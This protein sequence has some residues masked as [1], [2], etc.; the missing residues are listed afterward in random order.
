[1][2]RRDGAIDASRRAG[3][4][5][6]LRE[7]LA[8]FGLTPALFRQAL[9]HRSYCAEAPSQ[10]S[11]ERLEL[12][13]DAVLG[14]V[15]T[16]HLYHSFPDLPEGDLVRVRA[17]VVSMPGLA[18][19]AAELGLG[20]AILL[21]KGEESS[22][23]RQKSSILADCLEAVIGA[24]YLASGYAGAA[25]FVLSLFGE[26]A[27]DVASEARLGDPKGRL[28]E[29]AAQINLDPPIYVVRERGPDHAKHFTARAVLGGEHLGTGEGRSKK[30]AESRA[31]KEA[32]EALRERA[33]APA[34]ELPPGA[35]A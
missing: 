27:R 31:A 29:L 13:G 34:T 28:Q 26:L 25:E 9:A 32:F 35:D 30:D 17:A 5:D 22:G 33:L 6:A 3:A 4:T 20:E 16:D 19:V 18:P 12:L 11:N 10:A 23:G 1:M 8:P 14:L 24:V 21:G 7:R 2:P 15:V